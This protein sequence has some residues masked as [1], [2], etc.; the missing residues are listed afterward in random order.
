MYPLLPRRVFPSEIQFRAQILTPWFFAKLQRI[1]SAARIDKRGSSAFSRE[2]GEPTFPFF[3]RTLRGLSTREP[4]P[5]PRRSVSSGGI[6]E[7]SIYLGATSRP[8]WSS[9]GRAF[10]ESWRK[11]GRQER[12]KDTQQVAEG[13]RTG[14]RRTIRVG[15]GGRVCS[16]ETWFTGST[17]TATSLD[18][19]LP[20]RRWSGADDSERDKGVTIVR[21]LI[22]S[23]IF[24]RR[25][26][27]GADW[28]FR[29]KGR[30]VSP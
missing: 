15:T 21:A 9:A 20:S 24:V 27:F 14:Y 5:Q 7:G 12:R 16:T 11:R 3:L 4:T 23:R 29:R 26:N 22:E 6:Y 19:K 18:G 8:R 17:R 10:A 2:D 28:I 1:G 30:I 25:R 13:R